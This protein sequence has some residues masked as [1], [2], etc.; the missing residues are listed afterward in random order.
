MN[1]RQCGV[2]MKNMNVNSLL[3]LLSCFLQVSAQMPMSIEQRYIALYQKL[4]TGAAID[5]DV[6]QLFAVGVTKITNSKIIC[7]GRSNLLKQLYH[8]HATDR[9][10]SVELLET[11]QCADHRQ[12]VI[13][14][15][16][17]Y[18]NG[19]IDVVISI[20]KSD[21]NGQIAEINQVYGSKGSYSWDTQNE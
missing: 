2:S 13:R 20:F 7:T 6:V 19:D 5:E 18:Q 21:D 11:I 14:F 10:K 15:E 12:V 17:T 3:V 9:I 1:G 4:S 16:I 8:F